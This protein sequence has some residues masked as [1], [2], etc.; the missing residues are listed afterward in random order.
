[1]AY[2]EGFTNEVNNIVEPEPLGTI[3]KVQNNIKYIADGAENS[4]PVPVGFS[5]LMTI[6][7]GTKDTGF[8]I[9]N[10]TD[11][12]EFVWVSVG[13]VANYK[14]VGWW[15][16][17]WDYSQT[18]NESTGKITREDLGD[19][20]VWVEAMPVNYVVVTHGIQL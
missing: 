16:S 1:M 20:I 18:L 15:K 14:R 11:G 2:L 7:Q 5:P 10:D 12:N 6:E 17:D 9:K 8:V 19:S 4:I 13:N 3:L